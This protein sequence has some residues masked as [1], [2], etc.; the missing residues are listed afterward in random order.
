MKNIFIICAISLVTFACN[1]GGV[2]NNVSRLNSTKVQNGEISKNANINAIVP[3]I[4]DI[5]SGGL[6]SSTLLTPEY[7]LTAAHCVVTMKDKPYGETYR[8]KDVRQLRDIKVLYAANPSISPVNIINNNLSYNVANVK[9]ITI[10]YNTFKG[11]ETTK[12]GNLRII[13]GAEINDLAIIQLESPIKLPNNYKYPQLANQRYKRLAT[14]ITAGYGLNVGQGVISPD[15]YQGQAGILRT[16]NTSLDTYK[17]Q[18]KLIDIIRYNN[19]VYYKTCQG[20]SGG[21]DFI[22]SNSSLF[23]VGVH[24]FGSGSKCGVFY[25]P[26]TSISVYAYESW[27]KAQIKPKVNDYSIMV[28][29]NVCSSLND[30]ICD[31]KLSDIAVNQ[32]GVVKL[33]ISPANDSNIKEFTLK[34]I[35]YQVQE[36][37]RILSIGANCIDVELTKEQRCLVTMNYNPTMVSKERGSLTINYSFKNNNGNIGNNT[38]DFPYSR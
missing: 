31:K 9:N 2:V 21:P 8:D 30:K 36:G 38:Y 33:L 16:A 3:A 7:I 19:G 11:A 34:Y 15:P 10:H 4:Y 5:T 14:L 17:E 35:S 13:D 20:D 24:S 18:D 27:I 28:D 29:I 25:L 22:E 26:G 1:N 23:I 6:C 37:W 12:D 32:S